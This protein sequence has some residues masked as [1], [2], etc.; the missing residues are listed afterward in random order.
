VPRAEDEEE[1]VEKP[2]E[3]PVSELNVIEPSD[4][5]DL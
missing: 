1:T 3:E 2:V 5:D 4:T